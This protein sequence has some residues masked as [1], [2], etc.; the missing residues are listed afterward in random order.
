MSQ[1]MKL[2]S[3]KP[4]LDL[5]R[6]D[7][8]ILAGAAILGAGIYLMASALIYRIGFPLDD[9]W[10]HQ[11]YARN[12]A[13]HGQWPFNLDIHPLARPRRSGRLSLRLAFGWACSIFLD[14]SYRRFDSLRAWSFN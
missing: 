9:S 3:L 12:L 4:N 5:K 6:C 10:I 2:E 7:L 14:V 1:I 13:L 11:T 8:L